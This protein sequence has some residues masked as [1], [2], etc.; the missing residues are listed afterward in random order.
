MNDDLDGQDP[1]PTKLSPEEHYISSNH[2]PSTLT[3]YHDASCPR[4]VMVYTDGSCNGAHDDRRAGY[5]VYWGPN[6]PW[7]VSERL[8]GEQ[9]NNRAEIEAVICAIKQAHIGGI[10]HLGIVTDSKFT[11]NCATEWGQRWARNAWKLANG[12]DA[13]LREPVKRLLGV[14]AESGIE[15]IWMSQMLTID[16]KPTKSFPGQKPG[17][18]GLRKPTKT[19]M[20]HGYTE[21]FIQSI[22]NAAVGQLLNKSQPVRLLLGGDGRY[23]VR[24]SLQSIIIPICLANGVSELFVGQNGILSTPA[25]SF[26]IRKHQ[27]DGGILLT[28]SHNPGGLNADFGIKYNCGNGGPAP[29]KLTD[30]IFAQSEKLT[31]YKTVKEPLNIQLDCIGST[32]YTLS[33]GQT[34]I[35][36]I[37][38]SVSDYADYMRTLFDFDAIKT[39]LTGSNQREPFKLLVSGLNGVMGPYIHEILCNQLG[40]NSELAIKSQPLEDFGGG[41]PDP[42]LTYAADLVQ[43]IVAD[44]SIAMAAA[45][46]GDGDRN[47]LIGRH[48]FFVSP[49]DSL[50]VIADNTDCIKYFQENGV[51]GFA[52]SMPTSRAL[53]LVCKSRSMQCYEVPTGWKFF[54]NLMD[55]KL[56]SLCGEESFGTG[57]DHIRE[58]DGLWALLAWLS[59]LAKRSQIGLPVDV[60]SIVM[61]HW[62]KYGRYFFTRYDYENCESSQGDEIMN[63]LKK[64]IDNNRISGHVYTTVSGRQFV[65]DFCDNFSYVDPVDGSHTTNQGFRLIFND[66]TRFVYRLSGTGSSGATLR[67]YVDTYESDPAKHTIA[68]QEYLKPHIELALELC[69]VTKITGRIAPSVIT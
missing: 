41:H 13:K 8:E 56:C 24:E 17:T 68:S 35:V 48:G 21:N 57:S 27:L 36:T 22:L 67:V 46:D 5:G 14:I 47:M 65:C 25:A 12:E 19:F 1:L 45:F 9:T 18:S 26:I 58:K 7:N 4:R 59:I 62:K 66:G 40:L 69:G 32:K 51:H 55:A 49:C 16:I 15:I 60:E 38:S 64:L 63:E 23:F 33:N 11:Q 34:P 3:F 44:S 29:E 20:E 43:M 10:T 61:E 6:H 52:R 30:A 42:N 31:S 50:A 54:G 39:L 2:V 53:N 37:I 28:A